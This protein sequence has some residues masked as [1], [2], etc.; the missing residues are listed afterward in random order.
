MTRTSAKTRR[1]SGASWVLG[2]KDHA[3]AMEAGVCP[4]TAY[5]LMWQPHTAPPCQGRPHIL[6]IQ[7]YVVRTYVL[8]II[9]IIIIIIIIIIHRFV[10]SSSLKAT[11]CL[12]MCA[13][14]HT[15]THTHLAP[16]Y[17]HCSTHTHI[18]T[19]THARTHTHSHIQPPSAYLCAVQHTH[20][21][22]S[23]YGTGSSH[24]PRI[25]LLPAHRG[26][27]KGGGGAAYCSSGSRCAYHLGHCPSPKRT[28]THTHH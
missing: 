2:P 18:H 7:V 11:Y 17:V 14:A 28:H 21:G 9:V 6:F 10:L 16:T 22:H 12:P 3:G 15:H 19:Y 1:E 5:V 23:T 4:T 24:L 25:P 20:T 8:H 26:W 27:A 13:A